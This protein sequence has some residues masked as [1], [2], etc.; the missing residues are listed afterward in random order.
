MHLSFVLRGENDMPL[1]VQ[2]NDQISTSVQSYEINS[3]QNSKFNRFVN[4]WHR[5]KK[6]SSLVAFT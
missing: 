2:I 6:R 3:S 5:E 4:G 1:I